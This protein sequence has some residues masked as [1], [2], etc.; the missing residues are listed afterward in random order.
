MAKD[1]EPTAGKKSATTKGPAKLKEAG[2]EAVNTKTI[3]EVQKRLK[4]IAAEAMILHE[5]LE[6]VDSKAKRRTRTTS[7]R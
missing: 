3:R 1:Q 5:L 4:A 7:S 2:R 6:T